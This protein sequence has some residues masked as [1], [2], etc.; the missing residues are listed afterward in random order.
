MTLNA[1]RVARN[2]KLNL[3][4]GAYDGG[5]ASDEECEIRHEL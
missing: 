2:R 1:A 3:E 4:E 5:M